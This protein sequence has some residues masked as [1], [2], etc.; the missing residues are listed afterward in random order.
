VK[1]KRDSENKFIDPE[2]LFKLSKKV[3]DMAEGEDVQV[4]LAGGAAMQY[5][6]STRMTT[7]LDFI[8]DGTIPDVGGAETVKLLSFGGKRYLIDGIHTDFIVR[9]D[10]YELLYTEALERA[11]ETEDGYLIVSPEYLVAM[12]MAARRAKDEVDLLWLLAK[13]K[14]VNMKQAEDVVRRHV[15]G[16][17]GVDELRNYAREAR[18]RRGEFK[19][20][21]D[22]PETREEE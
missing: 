18:W 13:P 11:D 6:G 8:S 7:D 3:A 12:K 5:Y 2:R 20:L 17:Y 16:Q 15:G 4:A 1:R 14:L 10:D 21:E 9:A 19:D 22:A